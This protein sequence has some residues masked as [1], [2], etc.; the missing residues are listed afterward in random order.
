MESKPITLP[1]PPKENKRGKKQTNVV[2]NPDN[3]PQDI[4]WLM[5]NLVFCRND[6]D[7][8]TTLKQC[9]KQFGKKYNYKVRSEGKNIVHIISIVVHSEKEI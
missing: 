6:T 1:K 7:I 2:F 9:L 3:L 5:D 4:K 8:R